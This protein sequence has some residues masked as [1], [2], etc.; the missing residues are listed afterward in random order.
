MD[1]TQQLINSALFTYLPRDN[2]VINIILTTMLIPLIP[3]LASYLYNGFNKLQTYLFHICQREPIDKYEITLQHVK[4]YITGEHCFN[5]YELISLTE[6]ENSIS[7]NA[8]NLYLTRKFDSQQLKAGNLN[9]R[10][11]RG[12]NESIT[13]LEP[14]LN[15]LVKLNDKIELM[16]N[17]Q[18]ES[19]KLSDKSNIEKHTITYK[20]YSSINIIVIKEFMDEIIK[21]YNQEVQLKKSVIDNNLYYYIQRN[22]E[23]SEITKQKKSELKETTGNN[24]PFIFN[25]YQLSNHKSL[26]T[27][28]IPEIDI[29][30][31]IVDDFLNMTGAYSKPYISPKLTF[32]LY[33]PPGCGKTTFIKAMAN[34]TKRHPV[35][36]PFCEF[37]NDSDMIDFFYNTHLPYYNNKKELITEFI[38]YNKIIYVMEE[39]DVLLSVLSKRT[40]M[41]DMKLNEITN[42]FTEIKNNTTPDVSKSDTRF[43]QVSNS[44][45]SEITVASKTESINSFLESKE[46][47]ELPNYVK[48]EFIGR[49]LENGNE[50]SAIKMLKK[51]KKFDYTQCINI[52]MKGFLE[53][54]DG[55]FD[56]PGRMVI[57][58][59]NHPEKLDPAILRHGRVNHRIHLT[60]I[61]RPEMIKMIS[62]YYEQDLS[63]EQIEHLPPD[64][65]LAPSTIEQYMSECKTIDDLLCKLQKL[66]VSST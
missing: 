59:S 49:A 63:V 14:L 57:M 39:I 55:I 12:L 4:E 43:D 66:I 58:T 33:G 34:R 11:D 45:V 8:L 20:L 31:Q 48:E 30:K 61:N 53:V 65:L 56:C 16:C 38:P 54:L 28:F 9:T 36:V 47:D 27:L 32:L 37:K 17:W 62:Y 18:T 3:K 44:D 15:T 60:K 35:N 6:R 51:F 10:Y 22:E 13:I 7:I 46:F 40:G 1:I 42:E 25:R 2:P 21:E 50:Q 24:N 41:T 26:S 52:T 64:G 23:Y 5:R 29:I 19:S